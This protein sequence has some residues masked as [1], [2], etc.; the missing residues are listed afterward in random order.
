MSL[1]RCIAFFIILSFIFCGCYAPV[2]ESS[3]RITEFTETVVYEDSGFRITAKDI[4]HNNSNIEIKVI[5]ENSSQYNATV[6]CDTFIV[7]DIVLSTLMWIDTA[8]GAKSNGTI[9]LDKSDLNTAGI[10]QIN[11]LSS[12]GAYISFDEHHTQDISFSIVENPDH[13]QSINEE[14]KELY[15]ENGITIISKFE[16]NKYSNKIPLL[17]KNES[18]QDLHIGTNYVTING[19][20]VSEWKYYTPIC[21]GTYRFFSIEL[22]NWSLEENNIEKIES[23]S[24]SIDFMRQDSTQVIFQTGNLTA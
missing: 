23:A 3:A 8:A 12:Y 6:Y 2:S 18:G 11:T 14:G 5:A 10:E 4:Q 15:S 16:P 19:Y 9:Y 22:A 1:N 13:V 21:D 24:F 7:N 20:T 17:I